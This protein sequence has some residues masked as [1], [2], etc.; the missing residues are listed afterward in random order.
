MKA[1]YVFHL[2]LRA[3]SKPFEILYYVQCFHDYPIKRSTIDG[4]SGGL[5]RG[6]CV[7]FCVEFLC[8]CESVVW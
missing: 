2:A 1:L 8:V 5:A 7:E 6:F 3:S 4:G